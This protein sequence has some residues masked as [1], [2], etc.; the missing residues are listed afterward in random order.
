MIARILREHSL[1]EYLGN[2]TSRSI[3]HMST[4]VLPFY[5]IPLCIIIISC[6]SYVF[7][8]NKQNTHILHC[9]V[10]WYCRCRYTR[11]V[12]VSAKAQKTNTTKDQ[13]TVRS[14]PFRSI[15]KPPVFTFRLYLP[16]PAAGIFGY[17]YAAR[18]HLKKRRDSSNPKNINVFIQTCPCCCASKLQ[19]Q[20]VVN[21]L[22]LQPLLQH[23]MACPRCTHRCR[24]QPNGQFEAAA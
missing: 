3:S 24:G 20:G 4:F 11:G 9:A 15:P 5:S 16:R 6:P 10:R 23:S 12:G 22:P 2:E 19:L 17:V 13:R 1:V 21:L 7:L 14:I 8:P 18:G